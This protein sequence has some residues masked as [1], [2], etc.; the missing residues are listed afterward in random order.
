MKPQR[1]TLDVK[2][3]LAMPKARIRSRKLRSSYLSHSAV[4]SLSL[5]VYR[6]L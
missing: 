2:Y 6:A 5:L 3:A 4:A 1:G